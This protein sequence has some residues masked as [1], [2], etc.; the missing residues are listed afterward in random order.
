MDESLRYYSIFKGSV[1]DPRMKQWQLRRRVMKM[2]YP[3]NRKTIAKYYRKAHEKYIILD[4]KLV[5]YNH[6]NL[7]HR[8]YLL[9][10]KEP[11]SGIEKIYQSNKEIISHA[12][13]GGNIFKMFIRARQ[14]IDTL[15]FPVLLKNFCGDY[16]QTIPKQTCKESHVLDADLSLKR[17]TLPLNISTKPLLWDS[18]DW[19]IYVNINNKPYGPSKWTAK[20]LNLHQTTVKNRFI[21]HIS[22]ATYW[23]SGYFEK[24]YLMY[25]G[26]MLQV[27]T[28]Y[29]LGLFDRISRLSASAY[30]LKVL[31]DWLFI[32]AYVVDV[33]II[34]KHFNT[35]MEQDR[36]KD[37]S[38]MICYD[39][40]PRR[41]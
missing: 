12:I 26:V 37:F 33:K 21:K 15:G 41:E 25:T 5:I 34:I 3:M 1:E 14:D 13:G 9:Q 20:K 11:I 35:L 4:P 31:D 24:G 27:K 29:E 32:L 30:F 16:I 17:G 10:S 22:P 36:I 39:Y 40:L 38:Y 6:E 7:R 2:G 18:I 23:L 28:R 19:D 8:I